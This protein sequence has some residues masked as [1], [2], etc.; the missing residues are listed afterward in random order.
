M[1]PN[2]V[3]IEM[4]LAQFLPGL[5]LNQGLPDLYFQSSWN[6]SCEPVDLAQRLHFKSKADW[7]Q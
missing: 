7:A 2:L 4:G 5:A 3:L 6:Y 1:P